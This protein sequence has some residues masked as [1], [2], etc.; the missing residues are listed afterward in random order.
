M[1]AHL[2]DIALAV[3]VAW[4]VFALAKRM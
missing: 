3:G 2:S 4:L 1:T